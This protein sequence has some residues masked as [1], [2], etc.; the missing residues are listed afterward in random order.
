LP[1][2]PKISLELV[3]IADEGASQSYRVSADDALVLCA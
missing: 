3:G 1:P 2:W